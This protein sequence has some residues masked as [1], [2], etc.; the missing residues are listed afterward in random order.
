MTESLA[1]GPLWYLNPHRSNDH[2][3]SSDLQRMVN[4]ASTSVVGVYVIKGPATTLLGKKTIFGSGFIVECIQFDE[5]FV[6]TVLTSA[7]LIRSTD[8]ISAVASDI[9]AIKI[10]SNEI[11][12]VAAISS[13][14]FHFNIAVLKIETDV[15]IKIATL[16]KVNTALSINPYSDTNLPE[17][18]AQ[19]GKYN[20]R[21]ED[22][23]VA[24]GRYNDKLIVVAGNFSEFSCYDDGETGLDCQELLRADLIFPTVGIGGPLINRYGEVIGMTLH[25]VSFTPFLPTNIVSMCWEQLEK[26]GHC[27]LPRLGL[28]LFNVSDGTISF[29]ET[30]IEK[31]PETL[32]GV[33]VSVVTSAAP[34]FSPEILRCD[35][36]FGCDGIPI[37]N[38][39]ELFEVICDKIGQAVELD[40][41]RYGDGSHV[42]VMVVVGN[43]ERDQIYRAGGL[44][45]YEEVQK[46]VS[47]AHKTSFRYILW[48]D[49][50][51]L[52]KSGLCLAILEFWGI[53]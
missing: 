13:Y 6:S 20:L 40:V 49:H 53:I 7:S 12:C 26:N 46:T 19:S 18:D 42:K 16:R 10:V 5:M 35:V 51:L 17:Y 29:T 50:A 28:K 31:S 30:L 47:T 41:V 2:G 34:V 23:V 45:E 3:M 11:R 52:V 39:L 15:P 4:E 33:A 8:D 1:S 36:I 27:H 48:L 21:R 25:H 9:E 43:I 24:L 44:A 37:G 22:P 32:K 38:I 14:D